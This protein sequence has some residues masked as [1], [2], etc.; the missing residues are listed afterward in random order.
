MGDGPGLSVGIGAGRAVGVASGPE[1]GVGDGD[2]D[3]DAAGDATGDV[4]GEVT[5]DAAGDEDG[6]A[7][8]F[9]A[10]YVFSKEALLS[11]PPVTVPSVPSEPLWEKF[12][13][14]VSA[15]WLSS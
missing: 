15:A 9:G 8:D 12:F 11:V 2:A 4:A 7:D 1:V 6:E 3:G 14:M 10:E 5:G 13:G